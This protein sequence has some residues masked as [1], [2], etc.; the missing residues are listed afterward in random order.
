MPPGDVDALA[1]GRARAARRPGGARARPR[2]SAAGASRADLG[3]GRPGPPRALPGAPVSFEDRDPA[4]ARPLRGGARGPDR[5]LR[6][7]GARVRRRRPRRGRGALRRLPGPRRDRHGA[8]SRSSATA[9]PRPW[10]RTPP[11]PTRRSSTG[12]SRRGYRGSRS[13]SRMPDLGSLPC[14]RCKTDCGTGRHRTRSGSRARPG[15]LRSRRTRSTTAGACSSTRS[16][17]RASSRRLPPT[18]RPRSSSPAHGTSATR[19]ASS[20]GSALPV[21]TPLPDS[22][23]YLMREMGPHRRAGRGREP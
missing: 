14:A 7:R 3:R 17:R 6:R 5:R 20:S 8:D 9:S 12:R 19:G 22:A 18:A 11:R 13:E 15:G 21:Y 1:D 23:E 4:A 10:T 16:L 2:R